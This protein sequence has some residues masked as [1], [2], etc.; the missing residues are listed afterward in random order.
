MSKAAYDAIVVGAGPNGL[1]AAIVLAQSG[2]SV[3]VREG[4]ETWGGGACSAEITLPGFTHDICSAVYPLAVSSPFFQTLPLSQLGLTWVHPEAPVVHPLD[5]RSAVVLQRSVE[6]TADELG[7]DGPAYRRLFGPLVR[8]WS[9][10]QKMLL[11]P[12]RLPPNPISLARFGLRAFLSASTLSRRLFKEERARALFAGLAAHSTLPLELP[13]SAAFGMVLG[14]A[15]HAA[16]WPLARGGS[17]QIAD[18]LV[19]YFQ[20]LGGEIETG[21]KVEALEQ[22]PRSRVVLFDVTPRQLLAL[23]A[24]KFPASYQR[25]LKQF[26]YGLGA[27]KV[28]WAL[29]APIPWKAPECLR[30]ATVHLGGTLAEIAASERAAWT[31]RHSDQPFVLLAQPSLFDH[32]R[33]PDGKHTAWA[34]C[35]VPNGSNVDMTARIEDQIARFAPGFRDRIIARHVMPP[36]KLE[37]HNPNLIGGDI[38]GGVQDLRQLFTR[39]TRSLYSTPARELYICSSS[40]PPGGGVHGMCGYFAATTARKRLA[41]GASSRHSHTIS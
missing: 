35:H 34:Y 29:D 22:L 33:A 20:S 9:K 21:A 18:A 11:G 12:L 28:D 2:F 8:D 16:G 41:R 30:A 4:R 31:N 25:K 39:P 27:F 3:Q 36:A 14:I 17:Q 26:R 6:T 13:V 1:A 15:G 10:L 19:R 38:N 37:A 40:T 24:E 23:A 5:D 32:S 7:V